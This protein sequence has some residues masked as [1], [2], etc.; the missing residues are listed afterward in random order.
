LALTPLEDPQMK[1]HNLLSLLLALGIAGC[2]ASSDV[3]IEHTQ[4]RVDLLNKESKARDV[5]GTAQVFIR[6]TGQD[7]V[8]LKSLTIGGRSIEDLKN[9]N[10]VTLWR[11]LPAEV[12]PGEYA[13][14]IVRMRST[15][16]SATPFSIMFSD[17][18]EVRGNIVPRTQ[19]AGFRFESIGF[20]PAGKKVIAY[21]R[22]Y[23]PVAGGS[24]KSVT[25]WIPGQDMLKPSWISQKFVKGIASVEFTST[26]PLPVGGFLYVKATS[27][28]GRTA[29]YVIRISDGYIPL[30]TYDWP[31][32][33]EPDRLALAGMTNVTMHHPFT[34]EILDK[35]QALGLR[36]SGYTNY[37]APSDLYRSHKAMD[38]C[39]V[40]DEPDC[41]DYFFFKD[42]KNAPP[43]DKRVG[44]NAR[45][46]AE[47]A[48]LVRESDKRLQSGVVLDLTFVPEAY[49]EYGEAADVV[50][51][52]N[53]ALT[54]GAKP[55]SV[56]RRQIDA[57]AGAAPNP[58]VHLFDDCW[59]KQEGRGINRLKT[60]AEQRRIML[61]A[62]G[63]GAKGLI[64]WWNVR[65]DEGNISFLPAEDY[66][67]EW[68]AISDVFNTLGP[69]IPLIAVCQPIDAVT[70]G[71]PKVWTRA[72]MAGRQALLITA[73][74]DDFDYSHD[75]YLQSPAT[76][77]TL[78]VSALPWMKPAA[79]Y[80]MKPGDVR[81][82][83]MTVAKD[84]SATI[85]VDKMWVG[86]VVLV[87]SNPRLAS[88][89]LGAYRGNRQKLAQVITASGG[90]KAEGDAF[91]AAVLRDLALNRQSDLLSGSPTAAAALVR[92][93]N[94][95]DPKSD[96]ENAMVWDLRDTTP[97]PVASW[98]LNV[99]KWAR[100]VFVFRA[101]GKGAVD[102]RM[103]DQLGRAIPRSKGIRDLGDGWRMLDFDLPPSGGV[104][105]QVLGTGSGRV[106]R[107]AYFLPGFTPEDV[108]NNRRP[109]R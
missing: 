99:G 52:D 81:K 45:K 9:E 100:G 4:W 82:L 102:C 34:K 57:M 26:Q 15:P 93:E 24:V 51:S 107:Y 72:L 21:L 103:I 25:A 46:A 75:H 27:A 98:A 37:G 38:T 58:V 77:V 67:D 108:A 30:G 84:G 105:V 17:E 97:Q 86:E 41:Q 44:W 64:G 71:S 50:Y 53:Y 89:L 14:L 13:S 48:R 7:P 39:L 62:F 101:M 12:K 1:I 94:L 11:L 106:G 68:A 104:T 32:G 83:P 2:A 22:Q 42:K 74:N 33:I 19:N 65:S 69:L 40:T 63:V 80:L 31:N 88:D 20:S 8:T 23:S 36:A 55:D 59:Q 16:V 92:D 61:Y 76:A 47:G 96:Q 85:K 54:H 56:W 66:P 79:A 73:V 78:K 6:N 109:L 28:T 90:V 18:S 3:R 87:T 29:A 60:A 70:C 43:G 10:E 49:Y 5:P 95:L 35:L 91:A